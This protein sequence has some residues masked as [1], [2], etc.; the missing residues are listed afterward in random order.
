M[1]NT[2]GQMQ[3]R[4]KSSELALEL[5][6]FHAKPNMNTYRYVTTNK[7]MYTQKAWYR[8]YKMDATMQGIDDLKLTR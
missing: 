7:N 6:R 4:D 2:H 5:P 3:D 1:L 8:W